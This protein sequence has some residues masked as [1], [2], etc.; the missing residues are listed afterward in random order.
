MKKKGFV[1]KNSIEFVAFAAEENE[2]DGSNDYVNKAAAANANIVM[3]LNNDMISYDK[4]DR[5]VNVM[6]YPNSSD[7]RTLFLICGKTYSGL[8]FTH[9]NTYSE[10]G[11]SYSFYRKGY[12]ALFII[13]DAEDS[14]YHT[15][16]DIFNHYNY[17][18]CREVASVSCALLVQENRQ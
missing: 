16:D 6:D 9:D 3:M 7:L 8:N 13:N 14:Y 5:A 12:R 11:D 18:Y 4:G 17:Q 15:P 10:E 2:L 1:P